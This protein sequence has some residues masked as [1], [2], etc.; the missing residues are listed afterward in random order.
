[1]KRGKKYLSLKLSI[2]LFLILLQTTNSIK[3]SIFEVDIPSVS[4]KKSSSKNNRDNNSNSDRKKLDRMILVVKKLLKENP[5]ILKNQGEDIIK[6]LK[7]Q[8][9]YPSDKS[10]SAYSLEDSKFLR[11]FLNHTMTTNKFK[12]FQ[13]HDDKNKITLNPETVIQFENSRL[14]YKVKDMF[15]VITFMKYIVA[16]CGSKLENCDFSILLKSKQEKIFSSLINTAKMLEDVKKISEVKP[17]EKETKTKKEDSKP[18]ES[19]KEES[20]KSSEKHD[21]E[22]TKLLEKDIHRHSNVK[23]NDPVE[24]EVYRFK[25]NSK[26]LSNSDRSLDLEIETPHTDLDRHGILPDFSKFLNDPSVN[27]YVNDYYYMN[28]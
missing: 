18:E 6:I 21:T 1:M 17:V 12:Y 27:Q 3:K 26:S 28:S 19:K 2:A 4:K 24:K 5:N 23:E 15:E 25:E 10:N 14:Q 9:D 22:Q 11:E 16:I 13:L 8:K 7:E 20:V